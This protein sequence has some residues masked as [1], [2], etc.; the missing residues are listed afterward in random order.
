MPGSAPA[1]GKERA[2]ARIFR[3]SITERLISL[4]TLR[5]EGRPSPRK[6]RFRLLAR[7]CRTG[8]VTRWVSIERFHILDD[9]PFPSFLSQLWAGSPWGCPP[10]LP[11]IRTC[12]SNASGSSR[13]GFAVPHTIRGRFAVT[14]S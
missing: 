8:L 3:G 12:P 7:L 14:R 5:S 9:S 10:G 6:T 11:Q 2:H 13:C 4:S 1:A